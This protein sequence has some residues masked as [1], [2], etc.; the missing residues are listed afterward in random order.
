MIFLDFLLQSN[1]NASK[2]RKKVVFYVCLHAINFSV[3]EIQ[4]NT[5]VHKINQVSLSSFLLKKFFI[6]GELRHPL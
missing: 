3:A 1:S 4:L 6:V 5:L 2:T